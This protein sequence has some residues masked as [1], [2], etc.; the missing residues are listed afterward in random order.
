MYNFCLFSLVGQ[1]ALF[2]RFGHEAN[3]LLTDWEDTCL[4]GMTSLL[5]LQIILEGL[6]ADE[7]IP[8]CGRLGMVQMLST[9]SMSKL[10]E[11]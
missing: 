2:T 8:G 3:A 10:A 5:I 4:L 7:I 9:V 11:H 6:I 1:W